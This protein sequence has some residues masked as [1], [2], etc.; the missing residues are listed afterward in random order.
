MSRRTAREGTAIHEAG[1]MVAARKK[2]ATDVSGR[3][4]TSGSKS[5]GSFGATFNGSKKDEAVIMLAGGAAAKRMTGRGYE[6]D[7]SDT[8][9]AK[10]LLRG[11]GVSVRQARREADAIVRKNKAAVDREAKRLLKRGRK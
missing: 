9:A 3:V 4:D 6:V 1:H 10:R 11:S 5:S 7:R 2:G 8:R